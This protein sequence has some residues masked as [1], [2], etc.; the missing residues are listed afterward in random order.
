M[1]TVVSVVALFGVVSNRLLGN[2]EMQITGNGSSHN[3]LK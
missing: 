2:P 3:L 1:L